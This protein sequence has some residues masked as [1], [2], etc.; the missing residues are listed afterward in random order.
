MNLIFE[1]AS[2]HKRVLFAEGEDVETIK[3]A[4][5]IRDNLG[6]TPILVGR[7]SK[8][9]EALAEIG[10]KNIKGIEIINAAI[11]KHLPEYID[12]AY[13][14]LQ[15][16]GFLQRDCARMVKTDRNIFASCILE[17]GHADSLITGNTKNQEQSY[18]DV[19]KIIQIKEEGCAFTYH[20]LIKQ[21]RQIMIV[22]GQ[23]ADISAKDVA[24]IA[25]QSAKIISSL[26]IKPKLAFISY[27]N[28]SDCLY[29][30]R[31]KQAMKILDSSKQEFE[32][33]GEMCPD[34]ALDESLMKLYPFCKLSGPANILIMPNMESN[35]I[36][37]KLLQKASSSA[38]IIGP[39]LSGLTHS[40]QIVQMG[41]T[42]SE[43]I[44]L[45]AISLVKELI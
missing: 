38:Y 28:F 41:S 13:S 36:A 44:N 11:T 5:Q 9:H 34:V 10:E 39:I 20:I 24:Y 40:V 21:N 14:K 35:N 22:D 4:L 6:C 15:R 16:K 43:I 12:L 1:K 45:A 30:K 7:E 17:S 31:N 2:S 27:A 42:A 33:D 32:Y 25:K 18:L 37:L 29:S 19:S 26:G 23:S 3:A 8:I